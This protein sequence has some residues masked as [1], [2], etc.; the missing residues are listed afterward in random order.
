[1]VVRYSSRK[2]QLFTELLQDKL[3]KAVAYDRIA[4]YF[5]SSILDIAGESIEKMSGKVRIVCNSELDLDDVKTAQLASQ[6]QKQEWCDFKPEELPPNQDRFKRLYDFI[7]SGKLEVRVLPK[8]RFGLA[9]GKAGVITMKDGSKTAFLGSVNESFN[10]WKMN[11]ELVWEDNS[12][13]A[14]D[15]VQDEF[16]ELWNDEYAKPLCGMVIGDIERLSKREVYAGIESWKT[17]EKGA[18]AASAVVESPVYRKSFGLWDHQ[19]YFVSLAFQQHKT[20][21][22][23]RLIN[24]D[25]VGLGKTIQLAMSAMLMALWDDKPVLAL[26]PKTLQKQ[27][28][29]DMNELMGIPSAYWN[30]SGWIDE[31]DH[32]Y[33][34][35]ID[36]CPRRIGIVSQG[37][38]IN[39]SDSCSELR[40]QLLHVNGGYA[41]VLVDECHRARRSNLSSDDVNHKPQM[42]RLYAFLCE[43]SK[44]THSML[45]AT[46][47]PV[48]MNP[49]EAW[50]LLNILSQGGDNVLG[51]LGSRWRT[52]GSVQRGLDIVSGKEYIADDSEAWDWIRNPLP[53]PVTNDGFFS[54]IRREE[55]MGND[56][57]RCDKT[58]LELSPPIQMK[59]RMSNKSQELL[60]MNNPYIMHI[61][62]RERNFLENTIDTSTGEPYLKRIDVRLFGE[63]PFESLPLEG[64]L[65]D[66][67]KLAGDFCAMIQKRS[68]SAGLFKSLLLRR[69]GS[70]MLAGYRTGKS[71]LTGWILSDEEEDEEESQG[72][73]SS[74]LKTLTAAETEILRNFVAILEVTLDDSK[75]SDPKLQKIIDILDHGVKGIDGTTTK[76]WE[77]Y[78]CILFSQYLD[79]ASWVA[80]SL[81]RKY[82]D[83][84]IGLYAGGSSSCIYRNGEREPKEKNDLKKMVKTKEV[85]ILVGTDAA[86]E[87]LNLQT[88]GSLINIDL[89]WNPTRLEQRKGRIQRIGQVNPEVFI[90]NMKYTGSV[91]ERV[92]ELLSSRLQNIFDMFGQVPDVLEDIWI[93]VA[94]GELEEAKKRIEAIPASNPFAIKYNSTVAN[95]DWESCNK[96]LTTKDVTKV[97]SKGWD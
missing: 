72:A 97:M 44:K 34:L 5:C 45:L 69:I 65:A 91:E 71:M 25:Q 88:L 82:P 86:S 8:E 95:I 92:H 80:D 78:G 33:A 49:V 51:T 64:Y 13:D 94:V 87:G 48:Q 27:W 12:Q 32:Y 6:T 29:D 31:D 68:R 39:S 58:Y 20:R 17:D 55:G 18:D 89:P 90:Y 67:Y 57:S 22:G 14:V 54:R 10:G 30:G 24:A 35:P 23:A 66:A 81:S 38:I 2:R 7:K 52:I 47:T 75:V 77:K 40:T 16:D 36:K 63:S 11:Y 73:K 85:T 28:R 50:D 76:P 96:I 79:T 61:I 41:C 19:K 56:Q 53:L 9:H 37:I 21:D 74:D 93:D 3:D 46:A 62:R 4:G 59:V 15:W 83:K 84:N 42:N 1:M 60:R 70:S 43:I 26:V